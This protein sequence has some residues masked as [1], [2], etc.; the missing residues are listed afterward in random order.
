VVI[1]TWSTPRAKAERAKAKKRNRKRKNE[2][3]KAK[4]GD[5]EEEKEPVE[6][7]APVDGA[8]GAR[9]RLFSLFTHNED[10]RRKILGGRCVGAE[11]SWVPS[12]VV[13]LLVAAV[14]K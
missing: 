3:A 6:Y 4:N 9:V 5:E 7:D 13:E 2:R 1:A 8:R 10:G 11:F 12:T 14:S